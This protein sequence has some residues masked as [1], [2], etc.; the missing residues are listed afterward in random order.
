MFVKADVTSE[1]QILSM[2]RKAEKT[3]GGVDVLFNNAGI[4]S[5]PHNMPISDMPEKEWGRVLNVN[6]K[7]V[8]LC[9]R[10]VFP[11]MKKRGGGSII[12]VSS[13]AVL[14]PTP[15]VTP[16]TVAKAAVITLTELLAVDGAPHNIRVNCILPSCIDTP[17]LR[18]AWT[19]RYGTYKPII[20]GPLGYRI[21]K[22][23]EVARLV[24]FLSSD[25]AS[26]VSGAALKLRERDMLFNSIWDK[27]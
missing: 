22:P 25:E 3:Y 10:N 17:M 11:L 19:E 2:F 14:N 27:N 24:L 7:S 4:A 9:S 13:I 6:L 26:W 15:D 8:L 16:Y 21:G 1:E 23:E 18:Q 20:S 12:N 5:T